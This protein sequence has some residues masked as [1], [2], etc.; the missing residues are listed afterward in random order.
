MGM[1]NIDIP[2]LPGT[3]GR[4]GLM[5]AYTVTRL[6]TALEKS[7]IVMET[8]A[9]EEAPTRSGKLRSSIS[10]KLTVSFKGGKLQAIIAPH[11]NY[12]GYVNDGRGVVVPVNK[13]VLATKINPGWGNKNGAGYYIIGMRSKAVAPNPFMARAYH[14]GKPVVGQEFNQARRDIV[15]KMKG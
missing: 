5:S 3:V 7:A 6:T 9:K 1:F 4:F 14:K 10:H 8:L 12:A 13:K 2:E 11:V 15:S